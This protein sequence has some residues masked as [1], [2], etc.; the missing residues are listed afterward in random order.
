MSKNIKHIKYTVEL[1]PYNSA[2]KIEFSELEI[3]ALLNYVKDKIDNYD[4]VVR[5]NQEITTYN[6]HNTQ[7]VNL[8]KSQQPPKT[9]KMR[10]YNGLHYNS[11]DFAQFYQIVTR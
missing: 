9:R 8:L 10:V 6:I 4:E 3:S 2:K 7:T 11:I 1:S 5:V